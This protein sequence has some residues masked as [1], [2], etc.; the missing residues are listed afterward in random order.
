MFASVSAC[1]FLEVSACFL[2]TVSMTWK[3]EGMLHLV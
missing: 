2:K 3:A 1:V